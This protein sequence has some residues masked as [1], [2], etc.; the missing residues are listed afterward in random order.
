MKC[1][2]AEPEA[3]R[4]GRPDRGGERMLE[5]SERLAIDGGPRAVSSTRERRRRFDEIEREALLQALENENLFRYLREDESQVRRFEGEFAGTIGSAHALAV[6]SGTAALICGLVG[7][8]VGPGDEV[9]LPG[10]TY[11]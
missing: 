3:G 5:T 4:A 9:I 6:S 8:G 11:I 2:D 7:L 10:Y 1:A